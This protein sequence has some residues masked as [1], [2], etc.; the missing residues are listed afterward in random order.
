MPYSKELQKLSHYYIC[1]VNKIKP[2]KQ[3]GMVYQEATS[4]ALEDDDNFTYFISIFFKVED[5]T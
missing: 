1:I 2:Q 4:T 5:T 3:T